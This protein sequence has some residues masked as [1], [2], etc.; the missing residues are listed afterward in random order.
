[1]TSTLSTRPPAAEFPPAYAGYVASAPEGSVLASLEAEGRATLSVLRG[2][3]EERSLFRYAP[4]KWSIREITGHLADAERVF[5]YRA[6][7]FARA[8]AGPVPGFDEN[9]W[10]PAAEADAQPFP[11]LV[12][13]YATTRAATL[14]LFRTLPEAAW[15]RSG[16]A[17]GKTVSVRA[18]AWVIVGH[19][20]HHRKVLLDRYLGAGKSP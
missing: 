15:T 2:V 18:L 5:A 11:A 9:A 8:D 3:D 6:M 4:G 1:M 7:T 17:N 16:T 20:V 19:D 10:V 14:A 13:L 12:E